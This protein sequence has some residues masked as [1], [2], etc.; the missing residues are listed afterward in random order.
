MWAWKTTRIEIGE[1]KRILLNQ[2]VYR[3]AYYRRRVTIRGNGTLGSALGQARQTAQRA[4]AVVPEFVHARAFRYAAVSL[5]ALGTA[6]FFYVRF[7]DVTPHGSATLGYAPASAT[8]TLG[9]PQDQRT[10]PVLGGSGIPDINRNQEI[11]HTVL[12]GETF[13]EIAYVYNIS[14]EK[15]ALYNHIADVNKISE[16]MVIKVPSLAEEKLIAANAAPEVRKPSAVSNPVRVVAGVPLKVETEEQ[17]DGSG[18]TVHFAVTPPKGVTLT[19]F[20]WDQVTERSHSVP[21][22]S[23]PTTFRAPTP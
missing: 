5:L 1:M 23:G 2:R 14:I 10:A 19:S 22:R 4:L 8:L 6:L 9:T 3:R 15:L 13:S 16:G 12:D 11:L 20:V 7:S 18:K 21:R 17:F